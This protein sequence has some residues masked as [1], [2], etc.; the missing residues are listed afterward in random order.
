[1]SRNRRL[2]LL[3]NILGSFVVLPDIAAMNGALPAIPRGLDGGIAVQRL[4]GGGRQRR[5]DVNPGA[6]K[7]RLR[8]PQNRRRFCGDKRG[9]E[10]QVRPQ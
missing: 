7:V 2:V 4:G 3:A 10:R 1:M 8:L 5:F 9:S 6:W